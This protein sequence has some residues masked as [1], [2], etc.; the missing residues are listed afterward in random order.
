MERVARD[1]LANVVIER[2]RVRENEKE[3]WLTKKLSKEAGREEWELDDSG[4][5]WIALLVVVEKQIY[6]WARLPGK[7]S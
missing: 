5:T 4:K 3:G 2:W 1:F 6:P 7:L